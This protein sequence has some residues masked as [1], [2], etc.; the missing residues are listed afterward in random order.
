MK[1]LN[2]VKFKI[3]FLSLIKKTIIFEIEEKLEKMMQENEEFLNYFE[4]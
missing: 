2:Q 4:N 3:K 1:K